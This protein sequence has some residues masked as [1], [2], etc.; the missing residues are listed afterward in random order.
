[1]SSY[2]YPGV[3]VLELISPVRTIAGVTAQ[4]G[5]IHLLSDA[6]SRPEVTSR[7]ERR[8]VK[9][10]RAFHRLR[11]RAAETESAGA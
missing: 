1:M 3:Y 10:D 6:K 4:P 11:Q 5:Y 8:I 2:T 7:L 9:L